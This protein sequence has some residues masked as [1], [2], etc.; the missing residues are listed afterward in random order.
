M[1]QRRKKQQS[2]QKV[3][4]AIVFVILACGI[5]YYIYSI[6]VTSILTTNV[7]PL[8]GRYVKLYHEVANRVLRV[9]EIQIMSVIGGPNIAIGKVATLSSSFNQNIPAFFP[10]SYVNDNNK[11]TYSITNALDSNPSITIDLGQEM[12]I[13]QIRVINVQNPAQAFEVTLIVGAKLNVQNAD[14]NVVWT[15]NTFTSQNGSEEPGVDAGFST[16]VA[17]LPSKALITSTAIVT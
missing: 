2:S 16:Y 10:A 4:I 14:R 6:N 15:S 17:N 5:A 12:P 11:L 3:W 7:A 8:N 13:Q 9:P 1:I